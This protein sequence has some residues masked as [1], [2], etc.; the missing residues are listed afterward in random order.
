MAPRIVVGKNTENT[1][2]GAEVSLVSKELEEKVAEVQ[3]TAE[4]NKEIKLEGGVSLVKK[5]ET[6]KVVEM[7]KVRVKMAQNHRCHIG[8]EWYYLL[9]DK[10]YN[11]PEEVKDVL[12]SA[13]LLSPL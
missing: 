8:G 5:E 3:E 9:K 7:K 4:D 2:V 13:N 11:V 10:C 12:M 6:P 1:E